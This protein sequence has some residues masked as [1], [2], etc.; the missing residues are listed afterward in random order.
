MHRTERSINLD[1][2]NKEGRLVITIEG[3]KDMEAKIIMKPLGEH[4]GDFLQKESPRLIEKE[5]KELAKEMVEEIS[6][7]PGLGKI[8]AL[9]GE[10]LEEAEK[11]EDK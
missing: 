9:L 7:R 10:I 5:D 3:F 8:G 4:I 6:K 11:M 1:V 2:V